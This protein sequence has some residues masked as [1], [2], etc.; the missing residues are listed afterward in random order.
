[1]TT[2]EPLDEHPAGAVETRG[3]DRPEDWNQP[4]PYVEEDLRR[5][6]ALDDDDEGCGG[7]I[8]DCGI[9]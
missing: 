8:C 6:A 1:M 9:A 7:T 5:A 3:G 4:L 2:P